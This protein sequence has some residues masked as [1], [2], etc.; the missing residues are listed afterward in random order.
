MAFS[1]LYQAFNIVFHSQN[2]A[3]EWSGS[4][5]YMFTAMTLRPMAWLRY[6]KCVSLATCLSYTVQPKH[7]PIS[8]QIYSCL[9]A[10]SGRSRSPLALQGRTN[11]SLVRPETAQNVRPE[12]VQ[13]FA[14]P[15]AAAINHPAP[16][17]AIACAA[18]LISSPRSKLI[19]GAQQATADGG[20]R[21]TDEEQ[22]RKI[23]RWKLER[24]QRTCRQLLGMQV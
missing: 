12:T 9:E 6:N 11:D 22:R 10:R 3:S 16:P 18:A 7:N 17:S 14:H 23:E 24:I 2:E 20:K 4:M 15:R 8:A 1:I 13:P 21:T 5:L 19:I